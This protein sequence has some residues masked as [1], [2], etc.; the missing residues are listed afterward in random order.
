MSV[1][2]EGFGFMPDGTEVYKYVIENMNGCSAHVLTLGAT[3]QSVYAE[4]AAGELRDVVLGFDT[5]EDY[6]TKSNYQGATVG[7]YCNRIGGASVDINGKHYEL[8]ANEKGVT[9]L[10]AAGEFSYRVWR[11]TVVDADAVE[12][13]YV[14]P[15]GEGGFP[16]ETKAKALFRLDAQNRLHIVYSAVSDRDTYLNMTN[17]AY[18]NLN[19]F[20]SGDILGHELCLNADAF[21][22]SGRAHV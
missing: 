3:L 2:R 9:N 18:F 16:G 15:D 1:S 5:V 13:D 22:R 21:T 6:L 10:H 11:A 8:T 19:G 4:D 20:G 14:S 17:H 7:P 12:F